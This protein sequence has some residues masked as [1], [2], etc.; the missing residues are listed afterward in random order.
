MYFF[1]S[2]YFF[3]QLFVHHHITNR[4]LKNK[5]DKKRFVE[6]FSFIKKGSKEIYYGYML[7]VLANL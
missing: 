7:L 1:I 5:E 6:K 4:F 2:F 3:W